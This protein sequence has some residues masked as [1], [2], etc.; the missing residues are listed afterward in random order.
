MWTRHVSER[1][2]VRCVVACFLAW[3]GCGDRDESACVDLTDHDCPIWGT[4]QCDECGQGWACGYYRDD[5]TGPVL[6]R[7]SWPCECIGEDGQIQY[8]DS[9]DS[10]TNSDC[11]LRE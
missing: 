4:Y 5:G 10:T 7:T 9:A 1:W 8:Y 3:S 11:Q 6:G 2:P